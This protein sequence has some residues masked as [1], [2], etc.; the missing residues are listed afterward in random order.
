MLTE[1]LNFLAWASRC[2][3]RSVPPPT[4]LPVL[5]TSQGNGSVGSACAIWQRLG[6]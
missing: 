2:R 1:P 3:C 4:R 6:G 5:R